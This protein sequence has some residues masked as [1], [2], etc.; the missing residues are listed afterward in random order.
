MDIKEQMHNGD[1]YLCTDAE[2]MQEQ[3]GFLDRLYA[4][5]MTR[6]V[7]Q[8]K[9]AELLKSL[10]AQIGEGCYIEPPLHAN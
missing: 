8:E 7:E 2:L 3:L 1:L 5:N 9:R 6:P 10:F 4:Y